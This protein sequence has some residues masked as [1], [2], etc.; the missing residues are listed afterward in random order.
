MTDANAWIRLLIYLVYSQLTRF[1]FYTN[2]ERFFE[3]NALV[4]LLFITGRS[5]KNDFVTHKF[6]QYLRLDLIISSDKLLTISNSLNFHMASNEFHQTYLSPDQ[7]QKV[8]P[9]TH[10]FTGVTGVFQ[11]SA[12]PYLPLA[13]SPLYSNELSST[14]YVPNGCPRHCGR[15][16]C[17]I[18]C[19]FPCCTSS[20]AA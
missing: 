6:V 14:R 10:Y 3:K 13:T 15:K 11:N 2:V 20:D 8:N 19:P 4:T 12:D 9:D 7:R 5:Y 1:F 18:T 16:P 17:R